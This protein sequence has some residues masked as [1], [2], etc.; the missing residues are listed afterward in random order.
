MNDDFQYYP[1]PRALSARAWTKFKNRNFI[2]VLEPSA[3]EGHL[4]ECRPGDRSRIPVDCIEIDIA[5]HLSL[6]EQGFDV[7]GL[8]FMQFN[9]GAVYS[10]ILMNPPFAEGAKHVLKAWEILADGEIV[11]ILN[12][13]TVRNPFSKERQLLVRL[14]EQHGEVEY[15]RDAF[16]GPDSARRTDVEIAL[17]WLKKES[18]FRSEIVG[19]ILDDLRQ[20]RTTGEE[21]AY[22]YHDMNDV[23]LP[24]S[25]IENAVLMFN[26]AVKATRQ[27][28][29]ADARARK[30]CRML[31]HT[32]ERLNGDALEDD[33]ESSRE[34]VKRELY[35]R[36]KDLK[37]R[38]WT[39][40][41]RSTEVTSRLSSSAQ[42]RVEAEFETIKPFEFT[43]S[44]VYGFLQGIIEKQGEIQIGMACDVF[45]LITRYHTDNTVYYMGWKSNDKH[46]TCGM[47][48][49]TT[50]FVIPGHAT[51][52]WRSGLSW[53]SQQMLRDLD[54]VFAMLDGQVES[55]VS[56]ECV[57]RYKFRELRDGQRVSASYFDVRY[58][59]G[60]GTIHF[61]PKD[62]TLVDRLN[63]LVGR[64]RQW[65]PPEDVRV[66][67]AFWLQY[68][69]AEKFDKTFRQEI[70]KAQGNL[71]GTCRDLSWTAQYGYDEEKTRAQELLAD[72]MSATLEQH[73]I[74]PEGLL[75]DSQQ[76]P[77]LLAS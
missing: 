22:G 72:A 39:G 45:D 14:I 36:Y 35:K 43:V 27:A 33:L 30:Y 74:D 17:V 31:G 8:D 69:Q 77:R 29:L 53:D 57:F 66:S 68:E 34:Q 20:D 18:D 26:A 10:H 15:L 65:L 73:G 75:E 40:V 25:F 5:K 70:R 42:K 32:L 7:V 16:S 49:K 55:E 64:H 61:F 47:R 13:E 41:L 38:A 58:Y 9:S 21:L 60:V 44:N 59:P 67:D 37:N 63:R 6:R 50:R 52:A 71:R 46:R 23:A 28:V 56:L 62:K 11:V 19:S 12:A 3:G 2:R 54:K 76:M 48:I 4:L 24:N 51:E 1:T